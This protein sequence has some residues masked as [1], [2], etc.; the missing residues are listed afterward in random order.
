MSADE[1][2]PLAAVDPIDHLERAELEVEGRMPWSSNA[3][4]LVTTEL[5]G[6]RHRA[7]YK[8]VRVNAPCGTSSRVS[9]DASGPPS[10]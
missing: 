3:T 7:I 6:V 1:L 2:S 10:C 9:T 4:F 8:P 5:D